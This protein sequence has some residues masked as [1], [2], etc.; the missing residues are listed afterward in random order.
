MFD[1]IV[2][3]FE[4]AELEIVV[5]A[6]DLCQGVMGKV[7]FLKTRNALQAGNLGQPVRLYGEDSEVL[8][9][10]DVL[11]RHQPRVYE[12]PEVLANLNFHNLVLRHPELFERFQSLQI[13]Y[14][15][16][17][18]KLLHSKCSFVAYPY[19]VPTQFQ[20]PQMR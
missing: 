5:K 2:R 11:A 20:V 10:R 15:L 12:K 9:M 7:K 16:R 19:P 4:S 14:L 8:K 6:G 3:N 1:L 13:F 18:H 17:S